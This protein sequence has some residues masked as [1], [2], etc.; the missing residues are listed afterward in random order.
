MP[1]HQA[2]AT[3]RLREL[4]RIEAAVCPRACATRCALTL[5]E[6]CGRETHIKE[7]MPPPS[8]RE[9]RRL[10][11]FWQKCLKPGDCVAI[12]G[13][14]PSGTSARTLRKIFELARARRVHALIA[15]ANGPALETAGQMGLDGVKGN[16][17]E[18]G[19]WLGLP[20]KLNPA[21]RA[22]RIRLLRRL[23][24][25]NAPRAVLAT[26]GA[27]G[28]LFATSETLLLAQAPCC[29]TPSKNTRQSATG[30][31][32]AA[33][34]GW[35]WA[36]L[37]SGGPEDILRRAVACGTA[38]LASPDP[39]TLDTRALSALLCAVTPQRLR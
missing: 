9:E 22:H 8:A 39:G 30:C 33:T 7:A 6:P 14:A 12:C 15:D 23:A 35:L 3:R 11:A 2:D 37:E 21:S 20:G 19:A 32:D 17:A 27:A 10:L 38:K 25:K 4:S 16:A 28:A 1:A 26:L 5:L 29:E 24:L 34:A 13:S 36:L 31:G 18:I